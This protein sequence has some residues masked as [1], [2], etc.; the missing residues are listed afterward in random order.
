MKNRL[1]IWALVIL[2]VVSIGLNIKQHK[3]IE[4]YKAQMDSI[5]SDFKKFVH[6]LGSSLETFNGTQEDLSFFSSLS[7]G[8]FFLSRASGVNG[9][10]KNNLLESDVFMELSNMVINLKPEEVEKIKENRNQLS[11]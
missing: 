11:Q 2:L 9:F 4:R 7:K 10:Y 5:N 6:F 3:E 8:I 1:F